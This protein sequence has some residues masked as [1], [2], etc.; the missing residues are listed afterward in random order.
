MAL[1]SKPEA[2]EEA[3]VTA[4]VTADEFAVL[5]RAVVALLRRPEAAEEADVTAPAAVEA[6]PEMKSRVALTAELFTRMVDG[7]CIAKP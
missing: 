4:P 1:L 7:S 3:A 2:A 6:A 5:L